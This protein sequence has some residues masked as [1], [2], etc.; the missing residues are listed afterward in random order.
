[1]K[2]ATKRLIICI[3]GILAGVTVWPATELLLHFQALFTS[4]LLFIAIQ[5]VLLGVILGAYFGSVEGIFTYDRGKMVKGGVI[6]LLFGAAGGVVGVTVGQAVLF[7][8]GRILF[9][10]HKDFNNIALPVAR[11]VGWAFMG[12]FVGMADGFR[13]RSVK[14]IGIGILGGF[15]GGLVGGCLLEYSRFVFTGVPYARLAGLVFLCLFIALFY[16]IIERRLSFGVLKLL[17]G[18]LRGKEYFINQRRMRL[19]TAAKNEV[20]LSEYTAVTDLH[21]RIAV[22]RNEVEIEAADPKSPLYVNDDPVTQR[23]LKY[24][25]VIKVGSAKFFFQP[26]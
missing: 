9:D 8:I 14:K 4:Y 3:V 17:N 16:A 7:L 21:A 1:V 25:D 22:K 18:R 12:M 10:S 5:G 19:G 2:T 6:G 26:S 23:I 15:S 24:E 13:A 11:A 20:Q